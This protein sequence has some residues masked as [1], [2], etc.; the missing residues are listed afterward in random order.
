[1]IFFWILFFLNVFVCFKHWILQKTAF[2]I[3]NF[4]IF[5]EPGFSPIYRQ[6]SIAIR[7]R[8]DGNRLRTSPIS[9]EFVLGIGNYLYISGKFLVYFL[10]ISAIQVFLLY[11][12]LTLFFV[13]FLKGIA[14]K[15]LEYNA[16]P[17]MS[18]E[19]LS[20]FNALRLPSIVGL[21]FVLTSVCVEN[22]NVE[23]YFVKNKY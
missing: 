11:F 20:T 4:D 16:I 14:K 23:W 6:F 15:W 21:F 5:I 9:D 18:V 12:L 1:M 2:F 13:D 17:E 3:P 7:S 19:K 8:S 10:C 22:K